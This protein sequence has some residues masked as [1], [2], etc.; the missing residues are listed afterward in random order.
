VFEQAASLQ[1]FS[2]TAFYGTYILAIL[3]GFFV[4]VKVISK[5]PA[6]QTLGRAGRG[7]K[8]GRVPSALA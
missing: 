1:P 3:K 7:A 6:I 5:K 4:N 2:K 8:E